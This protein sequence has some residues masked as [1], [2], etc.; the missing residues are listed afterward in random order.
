MRDMFLRFL[1]RCVVL[2]YRLLVDVMGPLAS[3]NVSLTQDGP[4]V[5][6]DEAQRWGV[7]SA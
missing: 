6:R 2:G 4:A 1:T 7:G 5:N 3:R